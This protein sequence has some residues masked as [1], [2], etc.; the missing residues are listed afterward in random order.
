MRFGAHLPLI[1]FDDRPWTLARLNDYA[2]AGRELGFDAITANDHLVFARPWIDGPTALAAVLHETGE[3]DLMT[4]VTIA[5]VRGPVATA[6]TLAAIDI[7]SG[8]RLI[9]GIGPGS[10]GKDYEAVG[11][12]FDERWKRLDEMLP[13]LRALWDPSRPAFRGKFYSTEGIRLEPAPPRG[14]P[15]IWLGSWG[16]EAG[17]RRTARLADG[18]LASAYNTTPALFADARIRLEQALASAGRDASAFPN[19]IATM[20]MYVTEDAAEADRVMQDIVARTVAR[21]IEELRERL[22][23]GPAEQCAAKLRAFAE[24]GAQM[25]LLW[26][27]ADERTQLEAFAARVRP[28]AS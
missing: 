9:A 14:G 5:A 20:W 2:R 16:S 28:L 10:S 17:I 11:V 7:L 23:V 4:T 22:L 8:G 24:A 27:V 25:V 13:A 19:A 3:M 15:P 12:P 18:W 26:P 1:A 21:P 6:K